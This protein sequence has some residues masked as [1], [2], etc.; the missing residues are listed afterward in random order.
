MIRRSWIVL[1]ACLLAPAGAGLLRKVAPGQPAALEPAAIGMVLLAIAWLVTQRRMLPKWVRRPLLFWAYFQLLYALLAIAVDWR[2][3]VAATLIRIAPMA[4]A[5]IAY[6][7]LRSSEDLRESSVW[8][9]GLAAA[10]VPFGLLVALFGQD[11]VPFFLQP[12]RALIELGRTNRSGVPGFAGVFSTFHVLGLSMMAVF[13]LALANVAQAEADRRPTTRWWVLAL[14]AL[15]LVYLSTRRGAFLGAA[16]GLVVYLLQRRRI[17]RR[18]LVTAGVVVLAAV[19]LEFYGF[20]VDQGRLGRSR[21]EL[22]LQAFSAV[23]IAFRVAEVFLPHFWMWLRL[24]PFGTFLGAAGP[25]GSAMG[26]DI[27]DRFTTDLVEVGAAQLLLEM[28]WAGGILM[29]VVVM[30]LM[31]RIHRQSR[32]LRCHRAVTLLATYQGAFFGLYY[33]KELSAMTTVSMAQLIFWAVPG[34][35][36]ALVERERRE[37]RYVRALAR[38]Y[39]E[40]MAEQHA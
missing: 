5:P 36:A 32:G 9:A 35:A 33:L 11:A 27:L 22:L 3:G 14:A 17:P 12:I 30:L 40:T 28:G 15:A 6:A 8:V 25:E 4:M 16:I 2:I 7:A 18:W 1:A 13:Y 29:P 24:V 31:W 23:E 21:S 34:I 20:A 10:M 26:W 38:H 39:H 37:R 19:A